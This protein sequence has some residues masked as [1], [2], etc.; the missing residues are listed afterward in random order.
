MDVVNGGSWRQ[1]AAGQ[2]LAPLSQLP[3]WRQAACVSTSYTGL[4]SRGTIRCNPQGSGLWPELRIGE[5]NWVA[6]RHV[7]PPQCFVHPH[8]PLATCQGSV[9]P[10]QSLPGECVQWL[11]PLPVNWGLNNGG[12]QPDL[13]LPDPKVVEIQDAGIYNYCGRLIGMKQLRI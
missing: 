5:T 13:E 9:W 3:P 11:L 6:T 8:S 4:L 2:D 12:R 1:P 10:P 7:W